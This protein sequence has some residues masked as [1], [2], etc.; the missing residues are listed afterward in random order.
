MKEQLLEVLK[1]YVK[2]VA[3]FVPLLD[4]KSRVLKG[5]QVTD[6][7]GFLDE[8][9]TITYSFHGSSGV[10]L[11]NSETELDFDIGWKRRCDGFYPYVLEQYINNHKRIAQKF[12]FLIPKDFISNTQ[13]LS[14]LLELLVKEGIIVKKKNWSSEYFY[15]LKGVKPVRFKTFGITDE[16]LVDWFENGIRPNQQ[17]EMNLKK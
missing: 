7:S 15:Y 14:S 12:P 16:E 13:L 11:G 8:D 4:K 3:Y 6:P 17:V 1:D 9:K 10:C 5:F 2:D